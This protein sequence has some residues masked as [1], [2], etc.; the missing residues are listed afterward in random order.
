[1]QLTAAACD[2]LT[3][4]TDCLVLVLGN[5]QDDPPLQSPKHIDTTIE[6]LIKKLKESGDIKETIGSSIVINN[7]DGL[8]A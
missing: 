1:M 8:Q 7:P 4:K 2:L 3:K 6:D 5:Q